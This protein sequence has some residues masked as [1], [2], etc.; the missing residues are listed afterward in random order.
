VKL[1]LASTIK[2]PNSLKDLEKFVDGFKDKKIAYIP[3]A[4]NGEDGYGVWK[5]GGSWKAVNTLGAAV[6]LVIL[7][8]HRTE[9]VL[10]SLQEADILWF[11]G[12]FWGYLMYW[13]RRHDLE[14]VIP[15]LLKEGKTYVGSSAGANV[16]S[17]S[18]D[19]AE[20]FKYGLEENNEEKGGSLFRG[21]GLVDFDLYP[22]YEDGL[23][24]Y[25]KKNYKGEKMYLLKEGESIEVDNDKIKVNGEERVLE[26]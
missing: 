13:I 25:V 22:H 26:K 8:E 18:L 15:K 1:F 11:A 5:D 6:T 17:K 14:R 16:A 9:E 3:T 12:G 21:L 24:D 2:H 7:E 4:S 19:L 10:K 20:W 23:Y